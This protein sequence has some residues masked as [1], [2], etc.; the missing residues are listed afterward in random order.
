MLDALSKIPLKFKTYKIFFL[1][2]F[3]NKN[4]YDFTHF[5]ATKREKHLKSIYY[6]DS[7]SEA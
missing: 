6:K 1:R 7:S 4:K 3:G 2:L 5:K